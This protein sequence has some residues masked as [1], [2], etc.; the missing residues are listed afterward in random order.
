MADPKRNFVYGLHAVG[1][2]L[3]RAPERMLEFWVAQSRDDSRTR[4]LKDLAQSAGVRVQAATWP[5]RAWWLRCAR[6]PVG[7]STN[8]CSH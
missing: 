5:T 3:Q 8:C 6:C 2:V 1:A 7:T 4:G